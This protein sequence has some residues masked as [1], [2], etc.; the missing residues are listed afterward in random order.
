[1]KEKK[2]QFRL[3]D[4]TQGVYQWSESAKAYIYI[5]SYLTLGIDLRAPKVIQQ[6]QLSAALGGVD[7]LAIY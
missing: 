6:N 4:A 7:F 5:G 1:M 2:P 3:L